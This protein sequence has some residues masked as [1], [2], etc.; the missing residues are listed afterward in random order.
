M[1]IPLPLVGA[2]VSAAANLLQSLFGG[3]SQK[4]LNEREMTLKERIANADLS[5]TAEDRA[6]QRRN[7]VQLSAPRMGIINL[8]AARLGISPEALTGSTGVFTQGAGP[9]G[10]PAGMAPPQTTD[11]T[12]P[13]NQAP[14]PSTGDPVM[15][16]LRRTFGGSR[17]YAGARPATMPAADNIWKKK[18][19][20]AGGVP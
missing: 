16:A 11:G 2:G 3:G 9:A 5:N 14:A 12:L 10:Q 17:P 15:D 20:A 8:L 1:A 13:Y 4:K 19:A 18:R 7:D 6:T